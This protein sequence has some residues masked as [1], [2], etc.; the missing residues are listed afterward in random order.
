MGVDVVVRCRPL[1]REG[2]RFAAL[3]LRALG[4]DTR[5]LH[6]DAEH[7]AHE[8][9]T[10]L[11]DTSPVSVC[12][13]IDEVEHLVDGS[14]SAEVLR[15]LV[16]VLPGN[17]HL[18]LSGR[19]LPELPLARF[20]AADELVE[21]GIDEL[22]F[23]EAEMMELARCHRSDPDVLAESEGWPAL[24]RLRVVVGTEAPFDYLREEVVAA[25]DESLRKGL[26]ASVLAG[27]ADDDLL[28]RIGVSTSARA[29][30]DA[31]PLVE[32]HTDGS[33]VPHSLWQELLPRLVDEPTHTSMST[34]IA[35]QLAR[36]GALDEAL[37]LLQSTRRWPEARSLLMRALGNGTTFITSETARRWLEGFPPDE[38]DEP[39]LLLLAGVAARLEHGVPHGDDLV[40]SALHELRAAQRAAD[41]A[42]AIGELTWRRWLE[43]DQPALLDLHRRSLELDPVVPGALTTY[44]AT[45]RAAI[46]DLGGEPERALRELEGLPS[47]GL[48]P[49]IEGLLH[50]WR[51][52]FLVLLGRADEAVE[53]A[54]RAESA[55]ARSGSPVGGSVISMVASWFA[56]DPTPAISFRAHQVART[57]PGAREAFLVAVYANVMGASFGEARPVDTL[58]MRRRAN[59]HARDHMFVAM[60]A[61][62]GL[63]VAG[64]EAAA[65]LEIEDVL[66]E[67]GVDD[68]LALGE[69]RRFL[70]YSYVLV[71][72]LRD[73][74]DAEMLGPRQCEA[75]ALARAFVDARSGQPSDPASLPAP[76]VI[77]TAFPLPWSVELA[78]LLHERGRVEGQALIEYL[79][80]VV[81]DHCR[82]ELRRLADSAGAASRPARELLRLAPSP[83]G[84]DVE[85]RVL[86]PLDLRRSGVSVEPGEL[87]RRRVRELLSLLVL[88]RECAR[89]A[90]ACILWPELDNAHASSN[91]R[92]T[93]THLRRLLDPTREPGEAPFFVRQRGDRLALHVS[94]HLTVDL[95]HARDL[96]DRARE[97]ESTN[98]IDAATECY[99]QI[100]TLW[101]G[102]VLTDL[103]FND[104]LVAE[105]TEVEQTL[106]HA[107]C[108]G[109]ELLIAANAPDRAIALA[110][111]VIEHDP[112]TERAHRVVIAAA[113]QADDRAGAGAALRALRDVLANANLPL[114]P[115]TEMLARQVERSAT[116]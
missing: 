107:L 89:E 16:R 91:L 64:D 102:E 92:I 66:A 104:D 88:R 12:L 4:S 1:D 45:V 90:V 84:D 69:L 11:G 103:R 3:V 41:E 57:P 114:E 78:A 79:L 42:V 67:H 6:D 37:A 108:R 98:A 55:A 18:V 15:S 25:L 31:V 105:R 87:K 60:A 58:E 56:G 43:D 49:A 74:F 28:A 19:Q 51:S 65:R 113:L 52:S 101:R 13:I 54:G 26:A 63:V 35:D 94:D 29:I 100:A 112:L 76:P 75:R 27:A 38:R 40:V 7:L 109:A 71:P 83:P 77:F 17:A 5:H 8:L 110:R 115:E 30:A 81:G 2:E 86:R 59:A 10:A 68:P 46:L 93:V 9:A 53:A 22:A 44:I 70:P 111:R 21:V 24:C 23:D 97:Y 80:D 99:E 96:V 33:A 85:V 32:L 47:D 48:D 116:V 95:W 36:R 82:R 34:A 72:P 14:S 20:R 61:A 62:A 106:V 50:R 39:E 73:R